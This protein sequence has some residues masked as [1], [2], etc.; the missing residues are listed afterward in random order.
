MR[1]VAS[2]QNSGV[3]TY[4]KAGTVGF[5]AGALLFGLFALL[6]G[7]ASPEVVGPH[8]AILRLLIFAGSGVLIAAGIAA[9]GSLLRRG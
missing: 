1:R 8:D 7:S 6:T 9:R 5:I 4:I 3:G 2:R